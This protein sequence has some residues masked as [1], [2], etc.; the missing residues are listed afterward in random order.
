MPH[1]HHPDVDY[2]RKW[3]VMAA[4]AMGVFL[5]TI[6]GSIVNVALPTFVTE[7]NTTFPVVQW[8]VLSYMLAVTTLLLGVGRLADMVGKK[9]IYIAGMGIFTVS[10]ALCG[11]SPSVFWL[12]GFR[13]LQ[14]IGGAMV[15]GLGPAIVTEAFP[16]TERGKALGISG[17]VVSV[18]IVAGPTIGGIL[19]DALS[20]HWIFF[21]NVPIGIIG[22]LVSVQFL[23]DV[24][25][26]SGQKF[27][28]AGAITLFLSLSGLLLALTI[29][30]DSGFL[31]PLVLV[32]FGTWLVFMAIFVVIELKTQQPMVNLK[33]FANGLLSVNLVTAIITFVSVAGTIFLMPFYLE[34][35]LGHSPRTVGLLLAITPIALGIAAP[36]A[37]LL[38]DRFGPRPI[39]V[40]GLLVLVVGFAGLITLDEHTTMVGYI[41]RFLV[42][43]TG[44]GIFQSPNN[45]A[46]MGSAPR[47]QLGV[48]S[49]LLAISRVLGQTIGVAVIGSIWASSVFAHIGKRLVG[50]ATAAPPLAMVAGM[51][52]TFFLLPIL[53]SVG[54]L[55]GIWSLVQERAG[56]KTPAQT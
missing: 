30:Q 54:L 44:M 28:Y 9:S 50:G 26:S 2:S 25:P 39:T 32:L 43:G 36:I 15:M 21:V 33:L 52:D 23:P 18:G 47:S 6:D 49:G 48:V 40:A 5:A 56:Q 11:L 4:V 37:G 46:I 29:G 13:V 31:A 27:D 22:I 53:M 35:V 16:P 41:L 10:S 45:S 1:H 8:V 24:R 55:L 14:A 19:I 12:I 42:I 38:S 17:S 7:L 20:W 51:H 3:Y 34:N